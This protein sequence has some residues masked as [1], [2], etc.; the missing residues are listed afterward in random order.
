MKKTIIWIIFVIPLT[1][2]GIGIIFYF[3]QLNNH[4][5]TDSK[6]WGGFGSFINPFVTLSNVC[7]VIIFSILVYRFNNLNNRPILTFKTIS[8][9]GTEI[10][11]II[12][13]GAGP[14]LNLVVSYK[15]DRTGEWETPSVKC[16]SLGKNDTVNL[17]WLIGSVDVIGVYYKDLF[18]DIYV[19]I[20]GDD[21]TEIRKYSTFKSFK[22]NGHTY[23]KEV[24]KKLIALESIRITKARN[25]V[26]NTN[27]QNSTTTPTTSIDQTTSKDG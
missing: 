7:I 24:F 14:A 18:D 12:N 19:A 16:Y 27:Q 4:Y 10:W 8:D 13:I 26:H 1:L 22:I 17:D 20:V 23:T 6:D 3:S 25:Q 9:D 21:I 2:I 11:Q 15:K 5:S